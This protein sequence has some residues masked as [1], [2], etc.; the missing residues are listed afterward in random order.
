MNKNPI[1]FVTPWYGYFSGGAEVA[2][3]SLAEQLVKRKFTVQVLTTCCASPFDN[4]WQNTLPSGMEYINGVEVRRFLVN[5]QGEELYHEANYRTIN[6]IEAEEKYQ[7]QFVKYSINSQALID[8]ANH[9]TQGHVVIAIPYL[10]GLTYS[11]IQEL[12][13]NSGIIPC[14]HDEHQT[15]WITTAEIFAKSQRF[16]FLT[17]EEKTL[18]I[19]NFASTVGRKLVESPVIGVGVE[20]TDNINQIFKTKGRQETKY[21]N[22]K[23]H[24]PD[25]FFV[26]V[27]RKD[28]GKNVLL[29]I[30]YFRNY[31]ANG[32]NASL[33]FLGG[34]DASLVPTEKG[35]IDLGFLPEEDKYLIIS[36]AQGLINLSL[37]ESFSLVLMEAWLCE[38]PV[39][40]HQECE[41]TTGHCLKSKGGIP[42]VSSE[43]FQNALKVL[44]DKSKNNYLAKLG[45]RY[46]ESNY[47]WDSVVD[48]FLRGA[49]K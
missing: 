40:V 15:S 12:K 38:I 22:Y 25:N 3:R 16:F 27:G 35:F 11:L 45:K 43:E 42:I 7:R 48:C 8:Y 31:R 17:E 29:L 49:Y 13:G 6:G 33:V 23:Y 2:V 34:G 30:D 36:Q 28:I 20:L 32:G 41:V 39:I 14:L 10:Y 5:T 46:V 26:Y 19:E 4:W 37:N 44:S 1:T 24:L 21:I 47:S 9:N 18:A